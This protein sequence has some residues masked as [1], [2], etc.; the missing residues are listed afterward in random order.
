VW[1]LRFKI[2]LII[3]PFVVESDNKFCNL[4]V[5]FGW[6][7]EIEKKEREIPESSKIRIPPPQPGIILFIY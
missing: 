7:D 5:K 2:Y 4:F 1:K 6:R 3:E